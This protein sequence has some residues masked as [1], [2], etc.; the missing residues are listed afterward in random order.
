LISTGLRLAA[1]VT[2][3]DAV[4]ADAFARLLGWLGIEVYPVVPQRT[5]ALRKVAGWARAATGAGAAP[6]FAPWQAISPV[7]LQHPGSSELPRADWT[8]SYLFDHGQGSA[9]RCAPNDLVLMSPHSAR[10]EA[11]EAGN[12]AVPRPAILEAM[13]RAARAES[14]ERIVIIAAARQRNALARQLLLI[15][16]ALTRDG[17]EIEILAVEQA[18]PALMVPRPRWDALIVMPELRSIIFALLAEASG[19]RAPWPMLWHDA[20]GP[21][22]VASETLGEAGARLPLDAMA[23]VQALALTL[24]HAGMTS[25]ARRLHENSARLRESGTVTASRGSPAP[26]VT[27]VD[28]AQFVQL[29]CAGLPA[30]GRAAPYWRALGDVVPGGTGRDDMHL[31]IVPSDSFSSSS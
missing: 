31:Y 3:N 9:A 5:P 8:A 20:R 7:A 21:V 19:V 13:I 10:C 24:Q 30:S 28:D 1:P 23:L 18:L 22:L 11:E 12:P 26:Y 14:R 27:Q 25:A 2:P 6:Q 4:W 15:D 17:L 29:V 16:R